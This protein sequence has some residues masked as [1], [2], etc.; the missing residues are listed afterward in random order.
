MKTKTKRS[1][2]VVAINL[3]IQA[4]FLLVNKNRFREYEDKERFWPFTGFQRCV[5][6]SWGHADSSCEFDLVLGYSIEE[7][8][9]YGILIPL[10]LFALKWTFGK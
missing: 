9:I 3:S 1:L 2:G 10:I 8:I 4:V 7:F 5:E 6:H